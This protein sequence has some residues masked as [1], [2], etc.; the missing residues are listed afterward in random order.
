MK[1]MNVLL[2]LM[3]GLFVFMAPVVAP[4]A[5]LGG[6]MAGGAVTF[7]SMLGQPVQAAPRVVAVKVESPV[8]VVPLERG[9]VVVFRMVDGK[10]VSRFYRG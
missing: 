2:G 4:G 10:L 8:K 1:L 6:L 5:L 7:A 3:V 9:G